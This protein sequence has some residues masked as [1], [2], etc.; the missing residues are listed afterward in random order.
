LLQTNLCSPLATN[1]IA[2]HIWDD[3]SSQTYKD[4]PSNGD[5]DVI[6][7]MTGKTE[8]F[9]MPAGGRGFTRPPSLVALWSTA[10]YFVNNT[11]GHFEP[12]PSVEARMRSFDDSIRQLLWPEK[13]ERDA[14]FGN[15][16]P[17]TIDRIKEPAYLIIPGGH[18]PGIIQSTMGF[19]SWLAP[20]VFT[21]GVKTYDFK[22]ATTAGGKTVTDVTVAAPLQTF[23]AGAPVSGP[24]IASG[25][26]VVVFDAAT[27]ALTLDRPATAAAQNVALRTDAPDV[28]IKIGPLP[29]GTPI[30]LLAGVELASETPAWMPR[31]KHTMNLLSGL[32]SVKSDWVSYATAKDAAEKDKALDKLQGQ[33]LT[34]DKC[35]DFV[36][37]RGHYFGTDQ[38]KDEPG[39]S[40]NDKEALI[41]FLKT[42]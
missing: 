32:W 26:R 37:N 6:N 33:L 23:Q 36:I 3:F 9:T 39:L 35:P 24:G 38:F 8:K 12:E 29:V 11:L 21:N 34:M 18:L 31:I 4:L 16:V 22:G 14:K 20:G 42:F 17:G 41:A 13:R 19:W 27:K 1:A 40:D 25:S 15:A 2:N 7:P 5:V 30:N 10:P 28:G